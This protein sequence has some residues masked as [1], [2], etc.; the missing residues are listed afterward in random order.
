MIENVILNEDFVKPNLLEKALAKAFALYSQSIRQKKKTIFLLIFCLS[1]PTNL[2]GIG[3]AISLLASNPELA[4]G[5]GITLRRVVISPRVAK[6]EGGTNG[7]RGV[8][9]RI[10]RRVC[11]VA[12]QARK[13]YSGDE[14]HR[15]TIR[16]G[17]ICFEN[18]HCFT[19]PSTLTG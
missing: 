9:D 4:W 17:D 15:E 5:A 1:K 7:F 14:G 8:E 18:D 16:L 11:R 2:T 12:Q 6:K 10:Q 13:D 3:F 19:N